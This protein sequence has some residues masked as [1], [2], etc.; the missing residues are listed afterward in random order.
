[1]IQFDVGVRRKFD[2]QESHSYSESAT[3]VFGN[4]L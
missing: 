2:S 3:M 4:S 1:M